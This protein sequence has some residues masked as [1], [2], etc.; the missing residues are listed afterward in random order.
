MVHDYQNY[1][2]Y[3]SI[4]FLELQESLYFMYTNFQ[5]GEV[6]CFNTLCPGF[7]QV[8]SEIPLDVSYEDHISQ[9]GGN[10]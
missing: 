3:G 5:A 8:D 4:I 10:S 7:I 2:S 1:M 6:H 9:R